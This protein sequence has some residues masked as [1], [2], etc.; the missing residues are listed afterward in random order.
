MKSL[1]DLEWYG[2]WDE[3]AYE[4]IKTEDKENLLDGRETE[5]TIHNIKLCSVLNER[6]YAFDKVVSI[7]LFDLRTAAVEWVKYY[8]D[9]CENPEKL[10]KD[11]P[12]MIAEIRA[13]I[14]WIKHFFNLNESDLK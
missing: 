13:T 6:E 4:C 10:H 7:N 8:E 1:K 2:Y 11:E 9:L 14:N 12:C 5:K 3:S